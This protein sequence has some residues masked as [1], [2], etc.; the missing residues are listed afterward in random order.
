VLIDPY[1]SDKLRELEAEL[2]RRTAPFAGEAPSPV[3]GPLARTAG[4]VLRRM[5]ERLESWSTSAIP[6][7]NGARPG[8]AGRTTGST[9]KA[10]E[11]GC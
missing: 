6:E 5:G 7:S 4:R 2:A 9:F 8:A 11:E 3:L 1:V 10:R